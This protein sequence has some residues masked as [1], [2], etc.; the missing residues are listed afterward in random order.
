[1]KMLWE[2]SKIIYNTRYRLRTEISRHPALYYPLLDLFKSPRRKL[3][4]S[5]NTEIVIEGYPRSANTFA[6]AAFQVA[7]GRSVRIA[8]HL[9]SPAQ[10]KVASALKLPTII[11]IRDPEDAITSLLV[12]DT[13]LSAR[14]AIIYYITFYS[15]ILLYK[16][17]YVLAHFDDVIS[18]YGNI[19]QKLNIK[20]GTNFHLFLNTQDNINKV[21]ALVEEMDMQERKQ[22]TV[23]ELTVARPSE[24][25]NK[26]KSQRKHE[27][28]VRSNAT[29]MKRAYEIYQ[30]MLKNDK[31]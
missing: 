7:Q 17:S 13:L 1:M 11:L 29:L 24:L 10:V 8:R 5:K 30:N 18:N 4:V 26:L 21:L 14:V 6:V 27:L 3:K 9:H 28:Y 25:R 15:D 31:R 12:R 23:S 22:D 20:Y 16:D 2:K 19:I